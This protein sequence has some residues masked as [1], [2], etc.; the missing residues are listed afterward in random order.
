[1]TSLANALSKMCN[2]DAAEEFLDSANCNL[3]DNASKSLPWHSD[4][5]QLFKKSD[6]TSNIISISFGA[7]RSFDWRKKMD[8]KDGG[9]TT[10]EDMDVLTMTGKTQL[11]YEH[12]VPAIGAYDALEG[13]DPRINLTFRYIAKHGAKC[14]VVAPPSN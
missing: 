6:G 2:L 13:S 8:K 4:N 10:L 3:Y 14:P 11:F 1:M 7:S 9:M 5:E 12:S